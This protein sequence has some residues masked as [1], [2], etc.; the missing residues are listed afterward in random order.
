MTK[1]TRSK[2]AI[3]FTL[4]AA[5]LT[6]NCFSQSKK[7]LRQQV[8]NLS[9]QVNQLKL[10]LSLAVE[11]AEKSEQQNQLV[12][13]SLSE[14]NKALIHKIEILSGKLRQT[15]NE[16]N[17]Q[18]TEEVKKKVEEIKTSEISFDTESL[19]RCLRLKSYQPMFSEEIIM[20]YT[21][22]PDTTKFVG[23]L[24]YKYTPEYGKTVYSNQKV[25]GS[26]QFSDNATDFI[27]E[28]IDKKPTDIL[29]HVDEK[30]S[31]NSFIKASKASIKLAHTH[32]VP[33]DEFELTNCL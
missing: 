19:N 25:S 15:Q 6:S 28:Q 11:Q 16:L 26:M 3:A 9:S 14:V 18:K 5:A 29:F 27:I 13:D 21:I 7:E 2:Q 12:I 10:S 23:L 22:L 30:R 31:Y 32:H 33:L 24:K 17:H 1:F 4:I 8:A 20:E